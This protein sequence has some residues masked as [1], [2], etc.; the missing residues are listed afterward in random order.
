MRTRVLLSVIAI[1]LA[2]SACA[3]GSFKQVSFAGEASP[4]ID[5]AGRTVHVVK[6]TEMQDTVLES[7]IR[8]RLEDFLLQHGFILASPDTAELYVLATFGSGP[9]VVG[10]TAAVFRPADVRVQRSPSGQTTGRTFR[11]DRMEYLRVPSLEN[12]VWLMVLSS[13][14]RYFRET[15]QIRN[16]WRGEAAMQGKP[17]SLPLVAGY[18]I[19]P[20]LKYFGKGTGQTILLDVREKDPG[21]Q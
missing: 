13:D 9:R 8:V 19:V 6:N 5:S 15:G 3:A 11:P 7:R 1:T 2:S 12:S 18:L 21:L 4:V 14:A 20:A 10:S 17:E 16:L